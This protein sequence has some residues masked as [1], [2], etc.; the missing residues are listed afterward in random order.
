VRAKDS[1]GSPDFPLLFSHPQGTRL[2]V[3]ARIYLALA[4]GLSLFLIGAA[5]IQFPSGLDPA[6]TEWALAVV[7][8]GLVW[9]A[10]LSTLGRA[11]R[12]VVRL[13]LWPRSH[14]VVIHTPGVVGPGVN[15]VSTHE[16]GD[17]SRPDQVRGDP[18]G[19]S[20][21][22]SGEIR[23]RLKSG[24]SLYFDPVGAAFPCGREAWIDFLVRRTYPAPDLAR[25]AEPLERWPDRREPSGPKFPV[26]RIVGALETANL[27]AARL[28]IIE[29]VMERRQQQRIGKLDV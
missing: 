3:L 25:P 26:D 10:A 18:L 7:V 15:L 19:R 13:Q 22:M 16:F 17:P 20:P 11:R 8:V 9:I 27:E 14:L 24:T 6:P 2:R 12:T 1:D 29:S 21:G 5:A 28:D 4:A 23:I